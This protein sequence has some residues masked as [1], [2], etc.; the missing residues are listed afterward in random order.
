MAHCDQI[1]GHFVKELNMCPLADG[2]AHCLN[3]HNVITMY[4]LGKWP[5]A[6][7]VRKPCFFLTIILS[8]NRSRTLLQFK[9][10]FLRTLMDLHWLVL[11]WPF[12]WLTTRLMPWSVPWWGI[13]LSLQSLE[14]S[15]RRW[16]CPG[17]NPNTI[18][19]CFISCLKQ[20]TH[21]SIL[22]LCRLRHGFNTHAFF[23]P[24][25][26]VSRRNEVFKDHGWQV[27]WETRNNNDCKC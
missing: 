4:P 1:D 21:C 12:T 24:K 27:R 11:S 14:G 18:E 20:V 22:A 7:S 8:C 6:P 23:V 2:W 13:G 5:L 25:V 15:L 17:H 26:R 16:S 9:E 10:E 3:N 19:L